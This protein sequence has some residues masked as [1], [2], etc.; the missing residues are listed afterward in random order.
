MSGDSISIRDERRPGDDELI[1]AL[2]RRGYAPEG[3]RFGESFCD[4]VAET[5]AE[6][7]L[8]DP[9]RGKVWFAER[10]GAA[11]GCAAMV[12]RGDTGQLRWVVLA[13][14]GRGLGLGRAMV[15][16]ALDYARARGYSRV[17]LE[18]TDGLDA[19]MAIYKKLGFVTVHDKPEQLWHG[20]GQHIMMLLDL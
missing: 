20:K 5:V 12:D 17:F 14:E 9:A 8:D 10:D 15:E 13:P 6:A 1:V 7:E 3:E 4:F 2:H 11:I 19:S 16:R 18:T